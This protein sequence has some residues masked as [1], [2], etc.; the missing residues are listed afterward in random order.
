MYS[1]WFT[2]SKSVCWETTKVSKVVF[3]SLFFFHRIT[4]KPSPRQLDQGALLANFL[5]KRT[6]CS[7]C[8]IFFFSPSKTSVQ[9][10]LWFKGL[11]FSI[12]FFSIF[13]FLNVVA[14]FSFSFSFSFF[15]LFYYVFHE[16][17]CLCSC[18]QSLPLFSFHFLEEF[19][20]CKIY[21][22]V[23]I[24]TCVNLCFIYH[25]AW[26]SCLLINDKWKDRSSRY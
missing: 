22:H 5:H 15:T 16:S 12:F 1:A 23:K 14:F 9:A 21:F 6:L 4:V 18:W 3:S 8:A 24:V 10:L 2:E 17:D 7:V 25:A 13:F 26:H 19:Y 11:F 20:V